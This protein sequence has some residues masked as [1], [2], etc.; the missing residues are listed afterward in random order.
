MNGCGMSS[1]QTIILSSATCY[2]AWWRPALFSLLWRRMLQCWKDGEN[3]NS[4]DGGG[5]EI[6]TC[7]SQQKRTLQVRGK[8]YGQFSLLGKLGIHLNICNCLLIFLRDSL[9]LIKSCFQISTFVACQ[10]SMTK[11]PGHVTVF[12]H[13]KQSRIQNST[14]P[15]PT[16]FT[17]FSRV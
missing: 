16:N 17:L 12:L 2:T 4:K 15:L 1:A 11:V 14:P 5:G 7:G 8:V 10:W 9:P 6:N 3:S 13:L